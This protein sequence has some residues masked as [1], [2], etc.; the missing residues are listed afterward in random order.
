[1]M[2]EEEAKD[3]MESSLPERFHKYMVTEI[4]SEE[5]YREY[6]INNNFNYLPMLQRIKEEIPA[7]FFAYFHDLLCEEEY[8]TYEKKFIDSLSG[9]VS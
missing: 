1:M 9:I 3:F 8:E 4:C 7:E 6:M 2:T 5:D